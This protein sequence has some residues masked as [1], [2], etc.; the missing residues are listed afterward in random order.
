MIWRAVHG[1]RPPRECGDRDLCLDRGGGAGSRLAEKSAVRVGI[2]KA[3][4]QL[5]CG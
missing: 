1:G 4:G 3:G 2:K 5:E